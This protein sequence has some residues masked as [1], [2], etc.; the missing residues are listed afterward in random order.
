MFK[1]TKDAVYLFIIFWLLLIMSL[2]F[3][4]FVKH[5]EYLV[6][7]LGLLHK[8]KSIEYKHLLLDL[9]RFL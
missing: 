6:S 7:V 8:F 5:Y 1:P 2:E 3:Q 9:F 4:M